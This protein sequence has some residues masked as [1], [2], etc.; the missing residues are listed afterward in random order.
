MLRR[1]KNLPFKSNADGTYTVGLDPDSREFLADL[2]RQLVM[3]IEA[4]DEESTRR[5]FPPAY[6]RD[7]DSEREDEYRRFM[8]DD[9]VE[10][11][12]ASLSLLAETAHLEHL[13]HAQLLGW[14]GAVNDIRLVLG[15]QI[16]VYEGLD[17]DDLAE[18]DPR[19][20]ALSVYGWLSGVL[21]LI[22]M[23]LTAGEGRDLFTGDDEDL[24]FE[25][26]DSEFEDPEFEDPD[27]DD[28]KQE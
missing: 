26:E 27:F 16:D 24:E 19:R 1:R 18:N 2:P 23:G 17:V 28:P 12:R 9:L 8:R 25:F 10:S 22:V 4:G 5:L 13:T 21:E 7:A 11:K 3:V 14:M 15:T 20:P 6:H